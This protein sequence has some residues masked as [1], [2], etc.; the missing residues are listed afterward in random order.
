ME[1]DEDVISLCRVQSHEM[2]EMLE[3]TSSNIHPETRE[4]LRVS[5]SDTLQVLEQVILN[6]QDHPSLVG[7]VATEQ[8]K[9]MLETL[10]L[11]Q[12]FIRFLCDGVQ[13]LEELSE[14]HVVVL[15]EDDPQHHG[16]LLEEYLTQYRPNVR[17]Q[18]LLMDVLACN[19][20]NCKRDGLLHIFFCFPMLDVVSQT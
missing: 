8:P 11:L 19:S 9:M 4:W 10:Q 2:L 17:Q 15:A 18:V 1:L 6:E 16:R 13:P 5:I 3:S 12:Q 20:R 14:P 7:C